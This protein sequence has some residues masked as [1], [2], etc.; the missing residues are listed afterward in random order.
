M[1]SKHSDQEGTITI[2]A[3]KLITK[4]SESITTNAESALATIKK[5]LKISSEN[6]VAWFNYGIAL[7]QNKKISEA[8]RA[9]EVAIR[10]GMLQ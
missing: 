7:H 1:A 6:G 4:G 2:E 3:N 5:G 10:V 8:I 9:Y